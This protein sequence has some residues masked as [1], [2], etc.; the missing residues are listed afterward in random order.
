MS[1]T[2]KGKLQGRICA[3]CIEPLANVKVRLYRPEQENVV[4]QTSASEKLT[5]RILNQ[6]EVEEKNNRLL[7]ET[8][9]DAQGNFLF[10]LGK[11]ND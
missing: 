3:E 8:E 6:E 9:A 1:Y 5:F 11:E 7:A 10:E 4:A 2:F